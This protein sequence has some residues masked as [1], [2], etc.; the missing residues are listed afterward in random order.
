MA[1]FIEFDGWEWSDEFRLD[2]HYIVNVD[3]IVK[4]AKYDSEKGDC[5]EYT[6]LKGRV[7]GVSED[8][9]FNILEQLN[10]NC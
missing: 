7:I 3:H 5:V 6:L 8:T 4:I 10:D 2:A 1:Q 9:H